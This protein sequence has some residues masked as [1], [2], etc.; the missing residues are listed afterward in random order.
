[1]TVECR[2]CNGTG[3]IWMGDDPYR[4]DKCEG[5]GVRTVRDM[6]KIEESAR[7]TETGKAK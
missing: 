6:R 1:M 2:K 3:V 7:T 5:T 4:C